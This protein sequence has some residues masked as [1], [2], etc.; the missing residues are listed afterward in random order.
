[1][2][3]RDSRGRWGSEAGRWR[4]RGG[5]RVTAQADVRRRDAF[6]TGVVAAIRRYWY[7]LIALARREVQK[8][9]ASS[10]LGVAWTV[11]QP[12]LLIAVYALVFGFVL[13]PAG[14]ADGGRAFVLFYLS[15]MLPYLAVADGIQRASASLRDDRALLER[16]T[17]PGEVIPASRVVSAS[18]GEVVGLCLVVVLTVAFG[19]PLSPWVVTLPLLIVLRVVITCGF[20]WIV[21][22]LSVFVTDLAEVLSLLLTVWLF[23]TPIFYPADAVP[24]ALRWLLVVNPLHHVVSAYRRV[25][26][27]GQ[28]PLPEGGWVILWAAGLSAVGIWFF[29]KAL[30]RGKDFL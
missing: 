17:F 12:L 13:R 3:P 23:L 18:V 9:Y 24:H 28:A 4:R 26:L 21:S 5:V 1:M 25:L 27:E 19:R 14:S 16:D 22:I 29:R 11:F 2:E 8:R 10:M 20:A 6:D 30:D 15:G 7:P